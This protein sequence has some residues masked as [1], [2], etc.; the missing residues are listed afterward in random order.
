MDT[1]EATL[2]KLWRILEMEGD[3]TDIFVCKWDRSYGT[4][5]PLDVK[6]QVAQKLQQSSSIF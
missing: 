3:I 4:V 5:R 1:E 2:A 6:A